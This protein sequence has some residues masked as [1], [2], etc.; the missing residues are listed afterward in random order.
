MFPTARYVILL[1]TCQN[2][3]IKVVVSQEGRSFWSNLKPLILKVA[4]TRVT[5]GLNGRSSPVGAAKTYM[6]FSSRQTLERDFLV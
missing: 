6:S 3:V 1:T 5:L 4:F 2:Y